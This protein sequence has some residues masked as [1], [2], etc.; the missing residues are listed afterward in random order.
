MKKQLIQ[1]GLCSF[2]ILVINYS[3]DDGRRFF[4]DDE[5]MA[6][7]A[8]PSI[9]K[10]IHTQNCFKKY[11]FKQKDNSYLP[12]YIETKCPSNQWKFLWPKPKLVQMNNT[13]YQ[14]KMNTSPKLHGQVIRSTFE[15]G[16]LEFPRNAIKWPATTAIKI[17]KKLNHKR[18]SAQNKAEQ[19]K[20][21]V[22]K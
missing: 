12:D 13:L 22:K 3:Y 2:S 7:S 10:D 18:L 15:K 20:R 8:N 4:M 1:F 17:I 16:F 14:N 6:Y 9:Y 19:S 11:F 5:K 21:K